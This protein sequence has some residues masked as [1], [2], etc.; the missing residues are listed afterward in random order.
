MY[1]IQYTKQSQ[2]DVV[3]CIRAGHG[4]K[5]FNILKTVENNPYAPSQNF[6]RLLG[7]LSGR[8][9]RR[10]DYNNRFVYK[11]LPNTE[12]SRDKNGNLYDGIVRVY[13]AWGHKYQKPVKDKSPK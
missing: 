6:E 7:N 12:N 5:L 13:E 4:K 11:I 3:T 10:I 2:K 9:S 1:K 8:Y